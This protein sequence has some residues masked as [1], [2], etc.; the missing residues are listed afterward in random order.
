MESKHPDQNGERIEVPKDFQDVFTHFYRAENQTEQSI[1]HTLLPHFQII[2][3]F[4]LGTPIQLKT[5]DDTQISI[6][7]CLVL[8][9]L[10]Q[11]FDYTLAP[12]SDMLVANFKDDAFY[13]FFGKVILSDY[14]PIH[15][16]A[17]LG[18]NCF[19]NLW[20]LIKNASPGERVDL[21]LDFCKPY[22]RESD[23]AFQNISDH[24][25]D[26][27][28]FNPIKIIAQ[29]TQQSER[30]IQLNHKKYFGYTAKEK[31]RYLRFVKAISILQ[32]SSSPIH[33]FDIIETCG[34]YDQSQL[35]H[36][37][38]HFTGHTPTQYLKFQ[39]NIC[40]PE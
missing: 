31:G 6:E 37:F 12:G 35:I 28:V 39:E 29:E 17:L 36:D 30:S 10:K 38:K 8:G 13:R 14:L 7:K 9:P 2:M 5:A 16:D 20:R 4:S 1:S 25:E 21:I 27:T 26:Y 11:A 18:E 33:W 15:P 32:D 40:K 24:T 19:T 3:V 23:T 22:L 34:Y